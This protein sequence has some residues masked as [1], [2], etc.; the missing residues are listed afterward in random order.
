MNIEIVRSGIELNA[1]AMKKVTSS[2]KSKFDIC[3]DMLK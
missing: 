3:M 2:D 1:K